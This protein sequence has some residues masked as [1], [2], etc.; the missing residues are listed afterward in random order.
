MDIDASLSRTE[1][2]GVVASFVKSFVVFFGTH[3]N[4]TA[5]LSMPPSNRQKKNKT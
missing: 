4:P 3:T 5:I 1:V 2:L